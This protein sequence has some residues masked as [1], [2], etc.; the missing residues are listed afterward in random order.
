MASCMRS[1]LLPAQY[2]LQK[3]LRRAV[4][5]K[6]MEDNN[7]C[8]ASVEKGYSPSLRHLP[9]TQKISIGMLHEM[10]QREAT[11]DDGKVELIKAKSEDHLGDVMSKE[12]EVCKFEKAVEMLRISEFG[13][14]INV[15]E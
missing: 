14:F 13:K 4:N 7:A 10:I 5:A 9:R 6:V 3:L 15:E 1:E 12:L 2:L 8:I 11:E